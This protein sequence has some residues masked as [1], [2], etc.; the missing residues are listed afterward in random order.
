MKYGWLIGCSCLWAVSGVS[1]A[2]SGLALMPT[3]DRVADQEYVAELQVDGSLEHGDADTR[4]INLQVG[5]LTIMEFGVDYD[6]SEETA[7]PWLFNAKVIAL[8][9][10]PETSQL[11]LGFRNLGDEETPEGYAVTTWTRDMLRG[12]VGATVSE[13]RHTD[14]IVGLDYEWSPGWWGYAEWTSGKENAGAFGVNIPLPGPFD[15]MTG[16]VVPNRSAEDVGYTLHLVCGAPWPGFG[17]K[18]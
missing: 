11:A 10:E 9:N 7:E 6:A 5:A 17:K 1:A 3:A 8:S 15:L 2:P 12:H 14:A 4:F 13:E 18:D 16:V